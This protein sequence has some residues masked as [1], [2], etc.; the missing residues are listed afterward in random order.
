MIAE[1]NCRCKEI[2]PLP[3]RHGTEDVSLEAPDG[4]LIIPY[5]ARRLPQ[6][7]EL[8]FYFRW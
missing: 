8:K 5:R 1:M 2:G 4:F 6:D 3:P 7:P